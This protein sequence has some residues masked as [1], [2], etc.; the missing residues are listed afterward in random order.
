MKEK[1]S[2]QIPPGPLTP[3]LTPPLFNLHEY[4]QPV[5]DQLNE[6]NKL[7]D[8]LNDEENDKAREKKK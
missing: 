4:F 7:A 5:F 2:V 8:T 1:I 6:L 3:P